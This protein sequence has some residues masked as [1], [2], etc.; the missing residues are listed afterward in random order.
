M[1]GTQLWGTSAHRTPTPPLRGLF[2]GS[3]AFGKRSG[4]LEPSSIPSLP[5]FLNNQPAVISFTMAAGTVTKR[6]VPVTLHFLTA[7]WMPCILVP[8]AI[9]N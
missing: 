8:N 7:S 6:H 3:A 2:P 5:F 4:P 1:G 9:V